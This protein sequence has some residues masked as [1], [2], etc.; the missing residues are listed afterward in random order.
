MESVM[1]CFANHIEDMGVYAT[2]I[3]K[4]GKSWL[5]RVGQTPADQ[6]TEAFMITNCR[7]GPLRRP[8]SSIRL[9]RIFAFPAVATS[10]FKI[11]NS[12]MIFSD[13]KNYYRCA[14]S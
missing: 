8:L 12:F 7:K 14:F 13:Y 5:E 2:K 6:K 9:K 3:V 1:W 11:S 4:A 10:T